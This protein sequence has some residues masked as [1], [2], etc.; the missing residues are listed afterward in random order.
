MI[1]PAMTRAL[2]VAAIVVA[3]KMIHRRRMRRNGN[4]ARN[5][6]VENDVGKKGREIQRNVA[7]NIHQKVSQMLVMNRIV[8]AEVEKKRDTEVEMMI[9]KGIAAKID[10]SVLMTRRKGQRLIW[11]KRKTCTSREA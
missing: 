6:V 4:A 10:V 5:G 11:S 8:T 1:H 2:L 3:A 9:E 7:A